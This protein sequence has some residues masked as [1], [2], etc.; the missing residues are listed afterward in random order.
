MRTLLIVWTVLLGILAAA[1]CMKIEVNTGKI[2]KAIN[3]ESKP[4]YGLINLGKNN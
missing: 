3:A 1:A 4:S 2:D